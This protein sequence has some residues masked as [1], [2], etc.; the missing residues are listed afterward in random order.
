MKNV[1][2]LGLP[3]ALIAGLIAICLAAMYTG[4]LSE[5]LA[6]AFAIML[7]IGV[8]FNE[9]GKRIPIWNTYIGGGL[10]LAFLGS[11]A[12]VYFKAI[13]EK[14]V[15][16]MNWATEDVNFLTFF[17]VILIT[18]SILGLERKLL[19]RSMAGYI[20]AILGGVAGAGLIGAIF[21]LMFGISPAD[22]M[23][24]Y[25]LPIM[26]GGNGAGAVPLSQI[27]EKTTG[28]PAATYYSFAI[29]ILTIA[30]IFAI[31]TA[32]ILNGIG[33]KQPQLT[34][35]GKTLM[36]KSDEIEVQKEDVKLSMIDYGGAFLLALSFYALGRLFSEVLL[37]S[38]FGVRI[39]TFAYMIIFVVIAN[40]TGIIPTY[41][42][43]AAT[44]LQSFFTKNMILIIMVGVGIDTDLG[45][46]AAAITFS[47][48]VMAF[49]IVVGAI[50][51]SA[52]VGYLV[53]FYPIDSAVTAG[54]CMANR[55][56]SGDLAVLGAAERMD[57]ISYAQLSSRLGG[58]LVLVIASI[59]FGMF[60]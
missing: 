58:G 5:D 13:P 45:E 21:G 50:L 29:T 47:N 37:P 28:E 8:I 1:K 44:V 10:V 43:K 12:L 59:I 18:G 39:H 2:F 4:A 24:K 3:P 49:V 7:S 14:Y 52:V 9:I 23:I 53:G 57:L 35:D 41:V 15:T 42:R 48:V 11:S 19:L 34:G 55:G 17:I 36:R 54:L 22:V 46:L 6:G 33:K 25:V 20:P 16:L 51:G 31:I 56:G 40:A 60:L 27:Y 38:V 32:G 30:N 26:G